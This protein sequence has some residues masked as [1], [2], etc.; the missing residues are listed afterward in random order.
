MSSIASNGS[1]MSVSYFGSEM[2]VE[3]ALDDCF[4]RLQESLNECHVNSRSLCMLAEQDSDWKTSV[5]NTF[6]ITDFADGMVELLRELKKV[7]VQVRGKPQDDA[8]KRYL[9]DTTERRKREAV[10]EQDSK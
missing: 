9:K 3:Q 4:K 7:V 6:Q 2:A 5:D 1:T 10:R 8:E